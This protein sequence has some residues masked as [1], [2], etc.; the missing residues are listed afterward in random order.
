MTTK[1]HNQPDP[2]TAGV[3]TDINGITLRWGG[4]SAET[5]RRTAK[6]EGWTPYRIGGRIVRYR[7]GE[8]IAYEVRCARAPL[9]HKVTPPCRINPAAA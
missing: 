2:D 8:V 7:L 4:C 5:V 1:N 6:R 9:C 3:F